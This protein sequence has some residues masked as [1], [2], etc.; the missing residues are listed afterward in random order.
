MFE[1]LSGSL[2][3]GSM[4][5]CAHAHPRVEGSLR[6]PPL[7]RLTWELHEVTQNSLRNL[8]ILYS[9]GNGRAWTLYCHFPHDCARVRPVS[10]LLRRAFACLSHHVYLHI[11]LC[12][13]LIELPVI[14]NKSAR[15][16]VRGHMLYVSLSLSLSLSLSAAARSQEGRPRAQIAGQ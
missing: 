5:I 11:C 13:R 1:R 8:C 4:C 2:I 15:P 16:R 9:L 12:H 3:S 14:R 10:H 7:W 6:P